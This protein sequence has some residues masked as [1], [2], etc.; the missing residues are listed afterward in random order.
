MLNR[1]STSFKTYFSILSI[2]LIVLLFTSTMA[3]KQIKKLQES[4]EMVSHTLQVQDAINMLF[5]HYFRL[6]SEDFK[7]QIL[8]DSLHNSTYKAY[9]ANGQIALNNLSGL[10]ENNTSQK[11]RLDRIIRLQDSLHA[12]LTTR[13]PLSQSE[14]EK[15][16][17][18]LLVKIRRVNDGMRADERLLLL[19]REKKYEASKIVAPLTTLLLAI[20]SLFIFLISFVRMYRNKMRLRESE[21]FLQS[22]LANTDNIVNFYTP[23]YSKDNSIIDFEIKFAN[24][25]NKDIFG[26]EPE[27]ILGKNISDVYPFLKLNG[28]IQGLIACYHKGKP[29]TFDRQVILNNEKMWL[30]SSVNPL[31]NGLLVTAQN[32]T[33]EEKAK[34]EQL[35]LKEKALEDNQKLRE[36]QTFLNKVLSSS[37]NIISYFTPI[38][39]EKKEIIDFNLDFHND[40]IVEIAQ[41]ERSFMEHKPMSEVFPKNFENGVFEHLV[42]SFEENRV[43]KFENPYEFHDKEYW[44]K[45][46]AVK[47]DKGVLITTMDTTFEKN[48]EENLFKLNQRLEKQNEE[49]L[50]NSAFLTN[51]FKSIS[52]IVMY[53]TSIRNAEGEIIDLEIQFVN[54]K[55]HDFMG[56]DPDIV[57]MKKVSEVFPTIFKN[58]VYEKLKYAIETNT[59]IDY[60]T[61]FEKDNRTHWFKATAIKLED[62]VTVTTQ[63]ITDDKNQKEQLRVR[64]LELRKSN[65]EL[66]AFNR[67][68]SHD[69][70]EP[71]RKIQLFISRII[72]NDKEKLSE[73]NREYFGKIDNAASRMRSLIINLLTYSHI[74]GKHQD[75]E[76]TDLNEVLAKVKDD[77]FSSLTNSSVDIEHKELPTVKGV[78]YQ[79]EQLFM[80]LISNAVKY[81]SKDKAA[82][83]TIQSEKVAVKDIKEDFFKAHH[84]YFKISISD[85]GI[86]FSMDHASKIFEV[87]QRLHQK[88][89]Y[90]GTGIGLAICKKIV[91]NHHGYISVTSEPSV[92][93]TFEFYLPAA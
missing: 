68:A 5:S 90:S 48:T 7:Q 57:K 74:D 92:G 66:E 6:E 30:R 34:A 77:L 67:V 47:L 26:L 81:S 25:R 19:E 40:L 62:G 91:E 76:Q 84:H 33:D 13:R 11:L 70:Q 46:T 86:G 12:K 3:Y 16:L 61:S 45:S 50:Y 64:N 8:N 36:L 85:N 87:F 53:F 65:M 39:N 69:L 93:S 71:L 56:I 20:F 21:A 55:I 63:E 1:F 29:I 2:A 58:G 23:V 10:I 18:E 88:S 27:R 31:L 59:A 79:L 42:T 35:M 73:R 82:L 41:L 75:F 22:V 28:E 32:V 83:I 4:A 80:N 72:E 49:L 54:S 38:V 24:A 43:V 44:F 51:V 9:T 14:L 37:E 52:Q 89:E 78:P 17:S 60:E 15:D